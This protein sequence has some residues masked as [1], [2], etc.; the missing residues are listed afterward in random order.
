MNPPAPGFA[1]HPQLDADTV[2]LGTLGL[3]RVLLM[4]D[5]RYAWL[6]LVPQRPGLVEL[7]DLPMDAQVRLLGEI[8]LA[9]R[10]LRTHAQPDKLNIALLGN[11]VPQ[12]HVHVIARSRLDAAWP[13]PVWGVGTAV[14]Y[15]DDALAERCHALRSALGLA[16]PAA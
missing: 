11:M 14:P 2:A 3:S 6:L 7:S 16:T 15:A 13:R 10:A 9:A 1:L 4:N 5:A 8:D 12:L